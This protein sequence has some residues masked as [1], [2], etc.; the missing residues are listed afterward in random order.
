M[1]IQSSLSDKEGEEAA[2]RND[3]NE[4]PSSSCPSRSEINGRRGPLSK[5]IIYNI[6]T[7]HTSLSNCLAPSTN[8]VPT[9][10]KSKHGH[11]CDNT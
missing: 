7:R 8:V 2:D 9:L 6:N 1:C 3:N 4:S 11:Y 5:K 10:V